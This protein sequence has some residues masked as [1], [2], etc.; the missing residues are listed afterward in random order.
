MEV[1]ESGAM[2]AHGTLVAMTSTFYNAKSA[3]YQTGGNT[4]ASQ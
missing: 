2:K 3:E 4:D 1:K